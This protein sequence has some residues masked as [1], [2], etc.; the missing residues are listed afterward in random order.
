MA[1]T[2]P[3]LRAKGRALGLH[4][5]LSALIFLPFAILIAF[6]WFPAPLFFTD[7]GW[8]GLRIMLFVDLVIG[9]AL[10]F[11]VFN[12]AKSLRELK[13]DFGF[14]ALIQ[15]AALTYG[16]LSVDSQRPWVV[17][18]SESEFVVVTKDRQP[19]SEDADE[20]WATLQ[21]GPPYWA[22][23]R[24]PKD[25]NEQ[26]QRLNRAMNT[27]V[28]PHEQLETYQPLSLHVAELARYSRAPTHV[29]G[30]DEALQTVLK[31]AGLTVDHVLL[32][33]LN[34]YYR[35]AT[36]VLAR[37]D[38]RYIGAVYHDVMQPKA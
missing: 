28:A 24:P 13:L 25:I 20:A 3:L 18:F 19:R 12:P 37:E 26:L 31:D 4:L 35:S 9:P 22:F 27:D 30:F 1:W 36:L 32:L 29:A 5:G 7:G 14:I 10:T 23:V 21:P 16:Y 2:K 11:L 15:A 38:G 17:V 6:Y 33:P 34:G 8:Q